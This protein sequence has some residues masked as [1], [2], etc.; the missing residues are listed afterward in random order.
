VAVTPIADQRIQLGTVATARA[1]L[2]DQEGDPVDPS[3]A[4]TVHVTDLAGANVVA[5]GT[6]TTSPSY[7]LTVHQVTLPR[8]DDLDL[9]TATWTE[10]SG[11]ELTTTIE[12]C[13]RF[14]ASPT[15]IRA[16]DE[17]LSD[18]SAYPD[19]KIIQA[20][21]A[22]EDE[23]ERVIGYA[24]VP[25]IAVH[26][27]DVAVVR[28]VTLPH[29]EISSVRTVT[30]DGVALAGTE[31]EQGPGV[32]HIPAGCDGSLR[33]V[34]EHGLERPNG[35]AL[36]AFY[37]RVRDVLNRANRGINDRATTF[38][39]DIGGTYSLAVAGRGGSLTGIPDVD[40]VLRGLSRRTPG[41]A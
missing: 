40:V 3:G 18:T 1:Q 24:L 10:A 28:S 22:V 38:T 33:V 5:A 27:V 41:I 17:I 37:T 11:A 19:W 20:R 26:T 30:L 16:S 8:A 12:V 36:D 6:A 39:S 7:D 4:V 35:E 14:Y 2:V 25:R 15:A 23:F 9:Y 32:L 21:R 31:L 13:G 34:Y 29:V